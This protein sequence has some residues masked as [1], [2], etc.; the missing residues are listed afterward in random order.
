[1]SALSSTVPKLVCPLTKAEGFSFEPTLSLYQVKFSLHTRFSPHALSRD[2]VE[3]KLSSDKESLYQDLAINR[4][5][6]F[7]PRLPIFLKLSSWLEAIPNC[8]ARTCKTSL[9]SWA[10]VAGLYSELEQNKPN[11]ISTIVPHVLM[12]IALVNSGNEGFSYL[13][14]NSHVSP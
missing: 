13:K 8:Q 7:C 12:L 4:I 6:Q 1:M 5:S 9:L 14:I 10:L 3:L 2:E 11:L